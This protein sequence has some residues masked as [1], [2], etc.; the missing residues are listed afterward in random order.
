MTATPV[1]PPAAVPAE[2]SASSGV[3]VRAA[4]V[5]LLV[6]VLL[7]A[8]KYVA[9]V[10]TGSSAI[11]SDALESIINVAAAI[12]AVISL[13]FASRP[14]DRGH[15]YG[16][17]KIEYF[18]A[19]FEGGLITLAAL[20]IVWFALQDLLRGARVTDLE[21]GL[22][23]TIAAGIANAALGW[24]LLHMGRKHRSITLTADGH[25]VLADFKTS[26]GVV[27]GLA[28]VKL[29]GLAWFD[30]LAALAVGVSL[31]VTG[32]GVVRAASGGLLDE[33]DDTLLERLCAALEAERSPGII[34]IHR[35]RAIRSGRETHADAHVIV[36]EY[37]TVEEAH[38]AVV[39]FERRVFAQPT[40]DGDIVF[41]LDPCMQALCESCEMPDCPVRRQPFSS[42][43]ALTLDEVTTAD[44]LAALD[45]G[46]PPHRGPEAMKMSTTPVA[47]HGV[48]APKRRSRVLAM[49]LSGLFPGLGQLYN[50]EPWRALA[51]VAGGVLLL[52]G[53]GPWH[54]VD[55]DIDIDDIGRG[56]HDVVLA[57]IP[58]TLLQLWSVID[59]YRHA[60]A[61]HD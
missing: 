16:H 24:F 1:V 20:V 41:H 9:Y 18:S 47:R 51:F 8:V 55:I 11:L 58:F 25:H 12:V 13:R 43:V 61:P 27:V 19:A 28:L 53:I 42:R 22:A 39:G 54:G 40:I 7:L 15:P 17:G 31:G 14:P 6:S 26:A 60:G 33:E 46:T 5:S 29:T 30:P 45:H 4:S 3:R 2:S 37:W 44:V 34:R 48:P 50:R 52:R 21:L 32:Y 35:L 23:L 56:L 59:A 38:D 36:P 10:H 49:T 57:F